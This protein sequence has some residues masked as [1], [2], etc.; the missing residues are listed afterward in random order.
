MAVI[1]I[2][3]RRRKLAEGMERSLSDLLH[4][5][6]ARALRRAQPD[7]RPED[8]TSAL[9]A[10]ATQEAPGMLDQL[11]QVHIEASRERGEVNGAAVHLPASDEERKRMLSAV[12]AT[13]YRARSR[14]R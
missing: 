9:Y 11:Y 12:R 8:N 14:C 2:R 13:V 5:R 7:R 10:W 6:M 3:S 4:E 1:G